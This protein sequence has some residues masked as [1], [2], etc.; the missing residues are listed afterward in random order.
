M[1]WRTWWL[2][3][4]VGLAVCHD[5][6]GAGLTVSVEGP[7]GRA[8]DNVRAYLAEPPEVGSERE[9]RA[10]ARRA[11]EVARR[12]LQA[13]GYYDATV[14]TRVEAVDDGWRLV[15][16]VAPGEPV[17]LRN[18][19]VRLQ[20]AGRDDRVFQRVVDGLPL[21]SG[22]VLDHGAYETAKSRLRSTA[23]N[24]GYFD[25]AFERSRI[26]VNTAERW[27]DVTLVFA[28]GPRYRLGRVDFRGEVPFDDDLLQRLVPYE[29]GTAYRTD[30]IADLNRNLIDSGYFGDVEV[31]TERDKALPGEAVPVRVKVSARDPNTVGFG[32]GFSTDEGARV[33]VNWE[34]HWVNAAGHTAGADLR[35]SQVRQNVTGE[36]VIP[37]RDPLDDR[38]QFQ[39]GL[40]NE[41]FEDTRST[42]YTLAV[43]RQQH[44]DSGW[45]R[46]Q[47]LRLLYEDFTQ[48][49][50]ENETLLLMP[51]ISFS[52]T[53][54][55]GGVD[56]YWGDRQSFSLEVA[57]EHLLS[58]INMARLLVGTKLLRTYLDRHQ[59]S[60][61]MDAG[62]I[63]TNDFE[64]VPSSLRFF[65]GGDSSVRG[66]G[67]QTLAPEDDDGDLIGGRYLLTGSAEYGYRF[68]PSWRA[69][70]FIDA[71]NAFDD[72]DT[73]MKV[74]TGVGIRWIS[75]VGPVRVDF[76]WGVSEPDPPF[77]LHIS[78]GPPL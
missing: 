48:G 44:F 21:T 10:Y 6:W 1:D 65:A 3:V 39:T 74:G 40:Q 29:E 41:D 22:E 25:A 13:V 59:V 77:R 20:G 52:R 26:A 47:S 24:R 17:R 7:S 12:A 50:Q 61:R 9:A 15:A 38:L 72:V 5:V 35:I 37:L 73:D 18:V 75:P 51:G 2:A 54:S 60:L 28:T 62:A 66:F 31:M 42:R 14:D 70:A 71:G 57:E 56:P 34:R 49:A 63:A 68:A 55:R 19:G 30:H 23:L 32:A 46:V 36:Y 27:A 67:Y 76:A 69:A 53:R 4:L 16:T 11:V 43:R 58:D 33:R 78:L 8:L 45:E 64:A